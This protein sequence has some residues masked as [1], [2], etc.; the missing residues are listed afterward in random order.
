MSVRLGS[1][2]ADLTDILLCPVQVSEGEEITEIK[3][4]LLP[5]MPFIF[6]RTSTCSPGSSGAPVFIG[7]SLVGIHFAEDLAI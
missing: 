7:A 2:S 4:P 6:K 3:V 1:F 5:S